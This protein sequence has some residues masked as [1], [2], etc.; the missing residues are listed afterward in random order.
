MIA[1]LHVIYQ[2]RR[3]AVEARRLQQYL[4]LLSR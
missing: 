1:N 3:D 4:V 2:E